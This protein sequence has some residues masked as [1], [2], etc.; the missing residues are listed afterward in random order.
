[1]DT[2]DPHLHLYLL[3]DLLEQNKANRIHCYVITA[4]LLKDFRNR[5]SDWKPITDWM[6]ELFTQRVLSSSLFPLSPSS[7]LTR[8]FEAL[9]S[10]LLLGD[11]SQLLDPLESHPTDVL[12]SLTPQQREDITSSAQNALRQIAFKKLPQLLALPPFDSSSDDVMMTSQRSLKRAYSGEESDSKVMK[13][14]L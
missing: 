2:G 8:V 5:Q 4:R 11:G 7:A 3:S 1:M 12:Q 14:E 10:G 6:L 9:S 13:L